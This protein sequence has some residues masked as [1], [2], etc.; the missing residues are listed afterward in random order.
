MVRRKRTGDQYEDEGNIWEGET[1]PYRRH[2]PA[3]EERIHAPI[4]LRVLTWIGVVLLCFVVGYIG[5]SWGI[6]LL[7]QRGILEQA[8]L[9]ASQ[10]ELRTFLREDDAAREATQRAESL[11]SPPL[12]AKKLTLNLSI[13]RDNTLIPTAYDIIAGTREED[14]EE[15]VR[16][17]I[18]ESGLFTP[19]VRIAHVFRTADMLY[20]NMTGPFVQ[21]LARAGASD[22]TLF[23]TGV[24]RSVQD[25]FSPIRRVCFLVDGKMT[26]AGAPVDLTAIWQLPDVR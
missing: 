14:I 4:L 9:V 18:L 17:L 22:S 26:S 13:P 25:N 7:N 20:L 12:N 19:D 10:D 2:L 5:T 23:I 21:M 15:A 6:R 3:Q 8:D 16:K 11:A 1:D 24:V